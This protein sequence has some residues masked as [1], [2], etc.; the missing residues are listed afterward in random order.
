MRIFFPKQPDVL[1]QQKILNQP[2][3][4]KR[5]NRLYIITVIIILLPKS[6]PIKGDYILIIFTVFPI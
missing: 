4:K 2:K 6:N 3:P 5:F 1:V